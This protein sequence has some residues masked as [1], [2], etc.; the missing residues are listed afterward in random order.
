MNAQR[1]LWF[2]LAVILGGCS[3]PPRDRATAHAAA[4]AA[5]HHS[6]ANT[7]LPIVLALD[8]LPKM[9]GGFSVDEE[10]AA[11]GF[12]GPDR[13][14]IVAAPMS[15]GGRGGAL[16]VGLFRVSKNQPV[17]LSDLSLNGGVQSVRIDGGRLIVATAAYRAS[18][19]LCCPSGMRTWTYGMVRGAPVLLQSNVK[20]ASLTTSTPTPRGNATPRLELGSARQSPPAPLRLAVRA[21]PAL[22]TPSLEG[23]SNCTPATIYAVSDDGSTIDTTDG[24]VYTVATADQAI[25]KSWGRGEGILVCAGRLINEDHAGQRIGVTSP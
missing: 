6:V 24:S 19:R 18:D 17:F 23:A 10:R 14:M 25:S 5:A 3:S 16:D 1:M 7:G 20:W 2:S 13:T 12:I 8:R 4:S 15:A 9:H 11:V 22:S 21:S